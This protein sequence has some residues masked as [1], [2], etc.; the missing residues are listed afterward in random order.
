MPGQ[1]GGK[2]GLLGT[3]WVSTAGEL[4]GDPQLADFSR[5]AADQRRKIKD[6][7]RLTSKQKKETILQVRRI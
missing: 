4:V 1:L 5:S 7:W 2:S 3:K 6:T